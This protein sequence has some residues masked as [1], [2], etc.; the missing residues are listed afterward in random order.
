MSSWILLTDD[1]L[2]SVFP[3]GRERSNSILCLRGCHLPQEQQL[4]DLLCI[5]WCPMDHHFWTQSPWQLQLQHMDVM[6]TKSVSWQVGI[7]FHCYRCFWD[8]VRA[9]NGFNT[10]LC[11]DGLPS[12]TLVELKGQERDEAKRPCQQLRQTNISLCLFSSQ[13]TSGLFA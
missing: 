2:P 12:G 4:L 10:A 9:W 6:D 3:P 8:S 7:L 5:L 13:D 11:K 1:K